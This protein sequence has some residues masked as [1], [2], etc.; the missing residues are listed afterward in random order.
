MTSYKYMH[1]QARGIAGGIAWPEQIF[2]GRY[3]QNAH[4]FSPVDL[5][6]RAVDIAWERLRPR[7]GFQPELIIER[8]GNLIMFRIDPKS[9][10][11]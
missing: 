2:Q 8:R 4:R 10:T 6:D 9:I 5:I 1:I 7:A 3:R 11:T